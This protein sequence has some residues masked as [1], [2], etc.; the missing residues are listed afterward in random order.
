MLTKNKYRLMV[1]LKLKPLVSG[2]KRF[3]FINLILSLIAIGLNFILPYFYKIF[4]EQVILQGKITVLGTVIIG[5]LSIHAI[6]ILIDYIKNYG[7]NRIVNR[8]NY[9]LKLKIW[10]R[11]FKQDFSEY[12][13]KSVGDTKMRFE[14]DVNAILPFASSQ[15]IEY[16]ISYITLIISLVLLFLIEWRLALFSLLAIPTTFIVDH[17]LSKR[18]MILNNEQ[19]ENDQ[20]MSTW[21]HASIQGWKEIK[22]LNLEKNQEI[23][24]VG[25]IRKYALYYA[26]WINY[27]TMRALILPKIRDE[28][29]MKF[30]L[31]FLGGLLIIYE[32]FKIS[33]LLVF[34][35][36]Y[37][38]F[39]TAINTVS[40]T[41]ADLQTQMPYI[42]RVM[43]ELDTVEIH[44]KKSDFVFDGSTTIT[45]DDVS[46]RYPNSERAVINR[47]SFQVNK[48]ERVAI[49]GKSGS[50]KTTI[51][52]LMTGLVQPT[53]G[54][55]LF[56]GVDLADANIFELHATIG[57]VM[58]DNSLFNTTIAE[59]LLFGKGN[60]TFEELVAACKKA[61]IYDYINNLEDGFDTI[62]GE[63]G[64]KLSGGQRQRLILARL[65]LREVDIFIF[66]EATSALDQYSESIIHDAINSIPKDKTIIVVAHRASSISLCDR[67]IVLEES[68]PYSLSS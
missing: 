9:R 10:R 35:M 60:A 40:T 28:F 2:V 30:G 19:R 57:F 50:G 6:T 53:D 55:V 47:L 17:L 65:F 45:F 20:K 51:L 41:D 5:Y 38:M 59:N 11:L 66:D 7:N 34:S 64:V 25:F 8:V 12:E 24:F 58:Q 27:W 68:Q 39:S 46:F 16:I 18:E 26:K 56:A 49:T 44:T 31:Y 62:I 3:I 63:R 22:A 13:R 67:K 52:K 61:Y 42:N 48:G 37:G 54:K 23:R 15:T 43:E 14:D 36:Y 32:G 1:L 21:L 33:D 29:F 4:I